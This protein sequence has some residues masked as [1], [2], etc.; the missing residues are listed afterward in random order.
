MIPRWLVLAVLW[1]AL[2]GEVTVA[3][4]ATAAVVVPVVTW[5]FVRR[6]GPQHR[7]RPWGVLVAVATVGWS[8]VTSSLR[9][10]LAVL[11]PTPARTATSI[12]TVQMEGGSAFIA[13]AVANAITLTPGT[14]SLDL[15]RE[16]LELTVHVLGAVEPE[17]FRRDV[18]ALERR[19]ARA[20]SERGVA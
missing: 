14:M 3:N 19:L 5:L 9:V 7:L 8:L 4:L 20:V 15:D 13:S 2:W 6:R 1:V 12:Q 18:L 16:T 10:S 11:A 17:A